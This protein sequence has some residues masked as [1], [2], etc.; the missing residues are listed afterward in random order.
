MLQAV[1]EREWNHDL[2]RKVQQYGYRF[3]TPHFLSLAS[4]PV[5]CWMSAHMRMHVTP[6]VVLSDATEHSSQNLRGGYLGPLPDFA[7]DVTTRLMDQ[8][9][10][11]LS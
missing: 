2:K 7:R 10:A 5:R 1:E 9:V 11:S 8:G 6:R 4:L 3:G